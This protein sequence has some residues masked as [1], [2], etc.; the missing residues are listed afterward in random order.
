MKKPLPNFSACCLLAAM[1]TFSLNTMAQTACQSSYDNTFNNSITVTQYWPGPA[2]IPLNTNINGIIS[3]GNDL[4]YYKFYITTGG[5]IA[6]SLTNLPANYNLRLCNSNGS[7]IAQSNANGTANEN[8]NF[9]V[10]S[11]TWYFALVVPRNSNTFNTTAC[12]TLRVST[13][14]AAMP[15]APEEEFLTELK[16]SDFEVYPNP[17]DNQVTI[18]YPNLNPTS[19]AAVKLFN[20]LGQEVIST[21]LT[22]SRMQLDLSGITAEGMYYLTIDDR[23]LGAM[24]TKKIILQH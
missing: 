7:T 17:A 13:G 22:T 3:A 21:A 23:E 1:V 20:A 15:E 14:T 18:E 19:G 24:L 5:T 16:V 6:V 12:Y 2:P 8:I 10:T 11:N 4:D 9:T